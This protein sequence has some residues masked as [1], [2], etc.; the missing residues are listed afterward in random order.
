MY[1]AARITERYP[2]LSHLWVDAGYN[3]GFVAWA[4]SGRGLSVERVRK[5]SAWTRVPPGEMPAP[6]P[7]PDPAA[8]LG[9]GADLCLAGTLPPHEP[10]LRGPAAD[11]GSARAPLHDPPHTPAACL[12][13]AF[14]LP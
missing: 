12:M 7:L 14:R 2:E 8:A 5:G 6:R 10:G 11:P 1:R 4:Q 3:D 9:G 13:T